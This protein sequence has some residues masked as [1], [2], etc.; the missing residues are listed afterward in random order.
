MS[1][2][3]WMQQAALNGIDP[4]KLLLLMKIKDQAKNKSSS[5]LLPFLMASSQNMKQTGNSFSS[6]EFQ[7]I[8]EALKEGKT[9]EEISKME[10]MIQMFRMMNPSMFS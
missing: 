5:E 4:Q 7:F 8:F 10:K 1:N 6:Q 9:K 3:S 2:D